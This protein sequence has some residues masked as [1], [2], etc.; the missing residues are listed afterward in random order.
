[1]MGWSHGQKMGQ[2][3]QGLEAPVTAVIKVSLVFI[4]LFFYT[5][6]K[7]KLEFS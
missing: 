7:N 4:S 6:V 2:S 5:I 3:G 1:M